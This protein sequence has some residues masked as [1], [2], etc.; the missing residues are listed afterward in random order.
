MSWA[1]FDPAFQRPDSTSSIR[2]Y[3]TRDRR[4]TATKRDNVFTLFHLTC[5]SRPDKA[6]TSKVSSD[7]LQEKKT[8][9]YINIRLMRS[10]L[11]KK[12]WNFNYT[13]FAPSKLI[14]SIRNK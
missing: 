1:D 9:S 8:N 5:M 2:T 7:R 12:I 6:Q 13:T 10:N 14:K 4:K 11:I 3:M